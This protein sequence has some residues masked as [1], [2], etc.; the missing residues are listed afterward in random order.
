VLAV[1]AAQALLS[2]FS[3][4][5]KAEGVA[6]PSRRYVAPGQKTVWDGEQFAVCL[7]DI[8]RGQPGAPQTTTSWPVPT[9]LAAV[10]VIEL[11]RPAPM[12]DNEAI[13]EAMIPDEAELTSAGLGTLADA[14]S[15]VK[16]ALVVQQ[17]HTIAEA[18]MGFAIDGCS[19]LG[20][21]GGFSATALRLTISLD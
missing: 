4:Q 19:T 17:S 5:L 10:F 13:S 7:Q 6:V 12:L 8:V 21:E 2:A 15:L 11:V 16:A 9:V 1:E 18:G 14:Q 20:P 3:A